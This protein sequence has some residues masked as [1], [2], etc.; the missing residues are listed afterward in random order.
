MQIISTS[1]APSLASILDIVRHQPVMI[2]EKKKD[3]AVMISPADYQK[4]RAVKR[5]ELE[6]ICDRA[7][8]YAKSQGLTEEKLAQLLAEDD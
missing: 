7:S 5:K 4:L 6:D 8:A 2:Q 1:D 3:I